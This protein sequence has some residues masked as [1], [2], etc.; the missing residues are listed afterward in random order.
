MIETNTM[1]GAGM[2]IVTQ[3]DELAQKLGIDGT[4]ELEWR[5]ATSGGSG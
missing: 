3:R 1:V 4:V 2:K 5:F